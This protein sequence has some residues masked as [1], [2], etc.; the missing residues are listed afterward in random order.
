MICLLYFKVVFIA[1]TK[2][3]KFKVDIIFADTIN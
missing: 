3:V 2:N 1:N